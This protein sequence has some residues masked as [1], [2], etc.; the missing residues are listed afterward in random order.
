MAGCLCTLF[1]D[2]NPYSVVDAKIQVDEDTNSM[3]TDIIFSQEGGRVFITLI[4]VAI[5]GFLFLRKADGRLVD[6]RE[7]PVLQSRIPFVGHAIGM[8]AEG[9]LYFKRLG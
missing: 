4:L 2:L 6:P 9:S 5:V 3:G 1:R 7:P 8:V